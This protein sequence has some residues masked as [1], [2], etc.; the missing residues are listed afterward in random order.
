M[1]SHSARFGKKNGYE[2]EG[3][4]TSEENFREKETKSEEKTDVH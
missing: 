3:D 4:L 2:G 1:N